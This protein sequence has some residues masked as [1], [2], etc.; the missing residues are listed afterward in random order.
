MYWLKAVI[1]LPSEQINDY[2]VQ[3]ANSKKMEL[4]ARP[5]HPLPPGSPWLR[6]RQV[7]HLGWAGLEV[8]RVGRPPVGSPLRAG[9][10]VLQRTR[11]LNQSFWTIL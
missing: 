4:A 5:G 9:L 8:M 3:E 1:D 10:P 6:S 11:N 2:F 7:W